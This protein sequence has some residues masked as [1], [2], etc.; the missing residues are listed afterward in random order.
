LKLSAI[1]ILDPRG[2][3][4]L[5]GS[6]VIKRHENYGKHLT[7]L[8]NKLKL[9]VFTSN[10]SER[11]I[12]NSKYLDRYVL[13]NPTI[14]SFLFAWRAYRCIIQE[15]ID[16]K[17]LVAGDPWESF[18]T[19]LLLNKFL[20]KDI[21]IQMQIHGDIANPLWKNIKIQ[22][23]MRYILAQLFCK[24]A[25]AVRAVSKNQK[26]N[27]IKNLRIVESKISVI[28]VPISLESLDLRKR[29]YLNR[30]SNITI[31][32]RVHKDRGI[33]F[34]LQLLE[35]LTDISRDFSVIIIGSGK[36]EL[37]FLSSVKQIIGSN[38]VKFVGQVSDKKLSKYWKEIGVLVSLAPV[39][40]YGRVMR[41]AL[42]SGVPVWALES[43]GSN[44]LLSV[45][46]TGQIRLL[47]LN[48]ASDSLFREFSKL[49]TTKPN[50][51]FK[52]KFIEDNKALPS[53]LVKSWMQLVKY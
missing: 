26:I 16:V 44:D 42:V 17:L 10:N 34:F 22:N 48:S 29:K 13:S 49:L 33:T 2:N 45:E 8:S 23:R 46:K 43:S 30:P 18:W 51:N 47:N 25:T 21:P 52:D 9:V 3:I 7:S 5:G 4:S 35:K 11:I 31:I 32:G 39:E 50:S 41:E 20:R 36:D 27:L 1:L 53:H 24:K 40:S 28:P 6:D 37:E 15:R 14:N 19:A 38:K 12:Y